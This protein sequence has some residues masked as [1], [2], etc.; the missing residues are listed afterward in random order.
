[1]KQDKHRYIDGYP[2]NPYEVLANEIIIRAAN[3]YKK[4][5]KR[6]KKHPYDQRASARITECEKFFRGKWYKVLTEVDGEMLIKRL[7]EVVK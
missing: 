6:L 5:L 1:M 3:D 4:A 2:Q 7:R